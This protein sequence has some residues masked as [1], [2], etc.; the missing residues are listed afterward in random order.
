MIGSI[1]LDGTTS[2]SDFFS[3]D[4]AAGELVTIEVMSFSLRTRIPNTIDSLLR[5]YDSSGTKLDYF[6]SSLGAFNDDG[7]ERTDSILIDLPIPADGTY[8]VE[9]DTFNFFSEEFA[10]YLPDFDAVSFCAANPSHIGCSDSDTGTYELLLY[11]F[12]PGTS[13]APGNLVVGGAGADTLVSSSGNDTFFADAFDTFAGPR[14]PASV[15]E[16]HAPALEAIADQ[17]VDE[18]SLLEFTALG[19]DPDSVDVL[20]YSLRPVGDEAR[21]PEGAFIDPVT[22]E[23]SWT[24]S[25][26]GEFET[27]VVVTDLHG[28]EAT[29]GLRMTVI[30]TDL[31]ATLDSITGSLEEGSEVTINGSA[32][33]PTGAATVFTFFYEVLQANTVIASDTGVDLA[34]FAFAPE[35]E[36]EYLVRLTVEGD[37]GESDSTQQ[38]V[39]I[40]NVLP[41]FEAGPDVTIPAESAGVFSRPIV[42]TDPGSDLWTGSVNFG[43]SLDDEPLVIDQSLKSFTL[44][45]TFATEGPFIVTV[46]LSDQDGQPVSD[47]FWVTANLNSPPDA[48]DDLFSTDEHSSVTFG[49]LGNDVDDQNNIVASLTVPLTQPSAGTLTNHQDGTFTFDPAGEFESLAIDQSAEVTFTYQIT[50]AFG[51]SDSAVVTLTVNGVNNAPSVAAAIDVQKTEDDANFNVDLLNGASDPDAADTLNVS[52]L[53]LFSGD[54]AGVTVGTNSLSVNPAAYNAL[55]VGQSAV[56]I[57]TY[58]I[59]DGNDGSVPQTATITITG[60]N[61][62]PVLDSIGDQ[63]VNN[64]EVL[65]IDLLAQDDDRDDSL[66]YA[67]TGLPTFATWNDHGDGTGSIEFAPSGTDSGSYTVT[68]TVTDDGSPNLHSEQTFSV[69]VTAM[70]RHGILA[71]PRVPGNVIARRS[72]N[73]LIVIADSDD[74]AIRIEPTTDGIT[75]T[76]IAGTTVNGISRFTTGDTMLENL[77]VVAAGGSDLVIVSNLIIAGNAILQ[78]GYGIDAIELN[79]VQI[80][81]QLLVHEGD[82]SGFIDIHD[83]QVAGTA[84]LIAGEGDNEVTITDS[85]FSGLSVAGGS[86]RDRFTIAANAPGATSVS[87][88]THINTGGGD[89][90]LTFDTTVHGSTLYVNAGSGDDTVR[91]NDLEVTSTLYLNTGSGD[92]IIDFNHLLAMGT[93]IV[94]PGTGND[95]VRF[96]NSEFVRLVNMY[97]AN[98][99]NVVDLQDNL[100]HERTYVQTFSGVLAARVKGN[101]FDELLVLRGGSSSIDVLLVEPATSNVFT[102]PSPLV[103][104]F[105]SPLRAD[106][107]DT[108]FADLLDELF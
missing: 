21:F 44:N 25:D 34:S 28:L 99:S 45:H 41:Q 93:A 13:S 1:Q 78:G 2:E 38:T 52:G 4:A 108:V 36:G 101:T 7:F 35:D 19:S 48:I 15:L 42:F 100:F 102:G 14:A 105:E 46:T 63:T 88:G 16:N 3:F 67:V 86:G 96:L 22:G 104:G 74:H 72:G 60:E 33:D 59:V 11:Q 12:A 77:H 64:G 39:T 82:G 9:V 107:V 37:N 47:T 30:N 89:D 73:D 29:Q 95:A 79:D 80:G 70:D 40:T 51:V 8:F 87:S 49:V 103:L 68:V 43:E 58:D 54:A 75:V 97:F 90:E 50:D 92:D 23:F 26:D 84:Q 65:T 62:A 10:S 5:V 98:G 53:T 20:R 57:Y 83:S 61:D 76:G 6:G 71:L 66:S 69:F 85:A 24:P 31:A 91:G 55:A 27:L 17:Q 32:A 56:I 106:L 81:K 18:Y 94:Q